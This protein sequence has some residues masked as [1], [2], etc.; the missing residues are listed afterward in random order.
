MNPHNHK[1]KVTLKSGDSFITPYICVDGNLFHYQKV[2]GDKPSLKLEGFLPFN[3][4][5]HIEVE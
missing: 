4:V 3:M 2:S 1:M 5:D